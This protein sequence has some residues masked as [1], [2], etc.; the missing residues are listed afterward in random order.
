MGIG[1]RERA[2][3]GP[4]DVA[5]ATALF[6]LVPVVAAGGLVTKPL[7]E[8]GRT[9][10][11]FGLAAAASLPALWRSRWWRQPAPMLLALFWALFWALSPRALAAAPDG[12]LGRGELAG[13]A[14]C[15]FVSVA[16]V[17][18]SRGSRL[19]LQAFRW[20]WVVALLLTGGIGVWEV[21]SGRHLWTPEWAPWRFGDGSVIS[22][23]FINPNNFS[24]ALVGM[25]AGV[26]ALWVAAGTAGTG[27]KALRAVLAS[28]AVFAVGLMLL[29]QSR[30]GLVGVVV[31]GTLEVL[32]RR[33]VAVGARALRVVLA[34]H[35]RAVA[36]AVLGI[37]VL[38][39]ATF[40][41]PTLAARNPLRA[42]IALMFTD[43]QSRS[44][45]LR[46]RLIRFALGYLR[47][48]GWT[49]SGAGSFEP[50]FWN[51]PHRG[52]LPATN[53][54]N[55]FVEL[56][57]QYGV[58]VFAPYL[59]L[60]VVLAAALWPGRR[61]GGRSTAAALDAASLNRLALRNELAGQL[62]AFALLGVTASSALE[63]PFWWLSLANAVALA[64][65]LGS[66][67]RIP[68]AAAAPG[69]SNR[70][71]SPRPVGTRS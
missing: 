7:N 66:T 12:R 47:D 22:S 2:S 51:D 58:P 30:G 46:V 39:A 33:R 23:T 26:V 3:G 24:D 67:R 14:V 6:V 60:L 8:T 36:A 62:T 41:V 31:I 16:A 59:A 1:R 71:P 17:A 19:G 49:G 68:V 34:E 25:L 4:L 57:T 27:R 45:L 18:L 40:V 44:D 53:L 65:Y 29:T 50:L 13:L 63:I 9:G 28:L 70:S 32:R 54:H 52:A 20:G 43:E 38:I 10:L 64:W 21:V 11:V 35:R 55:A 69:T 56:L 61:T 5:A 15:T 48:S 42:T 37:L